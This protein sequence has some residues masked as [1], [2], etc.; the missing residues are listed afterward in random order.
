MFNNNT[1]DTSSY[2]SSD[3]EEEKKKPKQVQPINIE[4]EKEEGEVDNVKVGGL[5]GKDLAMMVDLD[6][7]EEPTT[8]S[9]AK[10][11]TQNEIDPEMVDKYAPKVPTLDELDEI[12]EFGSV[13]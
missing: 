11:K 13:V 4:E 3:N 12:V 9:Y 8:S 7:G 6:E 2:A 1:S 10:F 5:L